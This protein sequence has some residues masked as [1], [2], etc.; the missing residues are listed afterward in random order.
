MSSPKKLIF[1]DIDG[2]FHVVNKD[3]SGSYGAA[4]E[5][6]DAIAQARTVTD[7]PIH[8]GSDCAG[9]DEVMVSEKPETYT[10]DKDVFIAELAEISGMKVTKNYNDK[11][12]FI[13]YTMEVIE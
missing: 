4:Y 8:F 6:P 11:M 1:N 3:G 5:I 9:I 13:G 12:H 2:K 10:A 7:E